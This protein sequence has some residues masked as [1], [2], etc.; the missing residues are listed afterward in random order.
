MHAE[1]HQHGDGNKNC[2]KDEVAKLNSSNKLTSRIFDL[3]QLSMPFVIL[4]GNVYPIILVVS[5]PANVPNAY[6]TRHCRSPIRDVRVAIQS[7]QI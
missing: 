4:P 3:S 2:C 1:H 5:L 7:F 6:F